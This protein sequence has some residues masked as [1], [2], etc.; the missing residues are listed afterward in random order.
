MGKWGQTEHFQILRH[1]KQESCRKEKA[2]AG[3]RRELGIWLPRSD[4]DSSM[5]CR[6]LNGC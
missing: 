2:K 6:T 3:S 5:S 4:S 1:S